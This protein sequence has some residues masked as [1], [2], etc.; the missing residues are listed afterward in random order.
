[1]SGANTLN[2]TNMSYMFN[3]C[4]NLASLNLS[5]FD[6][7]NVTDTSNMFASDDSL[8]TVYIDKEDEKLHSALPGGSSQ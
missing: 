8:K 3:G 5:K 7:S 6:M 1:M 4:S 2:V